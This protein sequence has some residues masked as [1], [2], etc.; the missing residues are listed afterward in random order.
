MP[1]AEK[2][3]ILIVDDDDRLR[4][5]LFRTLVKADMIAAVAENAAVARQMLSAFEFDLMVLD[6]MMPGESGVEFLASMRG[7]GDKVPVLLLTAMGT[8]A[9][10]I[11]GLTAGADDYLVKPFEPQELILRIGAILR[12]RPA[13]AVDLERFSLGEWEI[14]LKKEEIKQCHCGA[15]RNPPE[16]LGGPG[17]SLSSDHAKRGSGG[18]DDI[19]IEKLTLV[20]RN[21]LRAF[22]RRV[23][24]VQSRDDLARA[25]GVNPDERTI[26]VQITRLRRRLND[27]PKN[28]RFIATLRGQGYQMMTDHLHFFGGAHE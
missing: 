23:G 18:R 16:I 3:H 28:P 26:D 1:H 4:D 25:C 15:G 21:L 27:D 24:V 5:L 9:D 20:E 22:V 13:P 17:R 7:N 19:R 6:V 12:R 8:P 14:D 10:R 11:G 2:P